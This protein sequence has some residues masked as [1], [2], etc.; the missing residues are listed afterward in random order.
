MK[1]NSE[2]SVSHKAQDIYMTFN[3]ILSEIGGNKPEINHP[4][5]P[6]SVLEGRVNVLCLVFCLLSISAYW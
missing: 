2:K 3:D 6:I 1:E 4:E 5:T